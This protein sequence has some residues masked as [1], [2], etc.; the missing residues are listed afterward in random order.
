[1]NKKFVKNEAKVK[2]NQLGANLSEKYGSL[3]ILTQTKNKI[4]AQQILRINFRENL[5]S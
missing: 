1:V 2:K 5:F 3:R 4:N